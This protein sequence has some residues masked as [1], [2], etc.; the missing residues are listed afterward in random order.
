MF[1]VVSKISSAFPPLITSGVAV[2]V[3]TTL[4]PETLACALDARVRPEGAAATGL[5][6]ETGML[7]STDGVDG[8]AAVV[9]GSLHAAGVLK[10][11]VAGQG[12]APSGVDAIPGA[13]SAVPSLVRH[14]APIPDAGHACAPS[15]RLSCSASSDACGEQTPA[16]V[17][18]GV[19]VDA[20]TVVT[21]DT[22]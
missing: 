4:P 10:A 19:A 13:R 16:P 21:P 3:S 22:G 20:W 8:G 9:V 17:A 18:H 14:E 5:M 12:S 15:G 7:G 2:A 1:V 11:E 6:V